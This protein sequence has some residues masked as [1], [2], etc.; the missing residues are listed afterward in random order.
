MRAFAKQ[1]ITDAAVRAGLAA[2]AVMDKPD[3]ETLLLPEQRMQLDY[4]PQDITRRFRRIHRSASE[5]NPDTHRTIRSR[6]YRS[7]LVVMAGIKWD[8][9]SGL[10]RF[11]LDFLLELPRKAANNDNDLVVIEAFKAVRGGFGSRMVEGF[12]RRSCAVHIN[13]TGMVCRDEEIP[14]ITDVNL[15]DGVTPGNN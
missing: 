1:T 6:L 12:T 5:D 13:F 14:L 3:R 15:V 11:V 4:L 2:A 8:R 10:D 7:V 9:E